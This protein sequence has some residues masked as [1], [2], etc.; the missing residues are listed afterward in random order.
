MTHWSPFVPCPV[1]KETV[2]YGPGRRR[3]QGCGAWCHDGCSIDSR[4]GQSLKKA[5][6][7]PCVRESPHPA[8]GGL[9]KALND[10]ERYP[11]L[12]VI[13]WA[14]H[15]G[16]DEEEMA[17]KLGIPLDHV[18]EWAARLRE[19]RIWAD[20]KTLVED[21]AYADGLSFSTHMILYALCATGHVQRTWTVGAEPEPVHGG[22]GKNENGEQEAKQGD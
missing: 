20:G 8:I 12:E 22:G 3:C 6:C 5:Y 15:F 19:Q 17:P 4:P 21:G 18:R 9:A 10:G 2:N 14:L 7:L 1:C 13:L 16:Q 11:A